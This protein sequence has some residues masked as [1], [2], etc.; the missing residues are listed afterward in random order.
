MERRLHVKKD[1]LQITLF[2]QSG[3]EY[4]CTSH[5]N[6]TRSYISFHV[7]TIHQYVCYDAGKVASRTY[8]AGLFFFFKRSSLWMQTMFFPKN[9]TN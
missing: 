2:D 5:N 1:T 9:D 3:P 4:D 8:R 6:L 7:T